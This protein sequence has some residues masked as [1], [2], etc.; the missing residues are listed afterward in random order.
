VQ[1]ENTAPAVFESLKPEKTQVAS[2]DPLQFQ[3]PEIKQ[4]L[5]EKI[6][7]GSAEKSNIGKRADT[8]PSVL[9]QLRVKREETLGGLIQK[10]YGVFNSAYL[11]SLIRINPHIA[12]PDT[13]DVGEVILFPAVPARVKQQPLKQWWVEI[14]NEDSIEAAFKRIRNYPNDAPLSHL[15]P[16]WNQ[17]SGLNF[18]ILLNQYFY[19]EASAMSKIKSL[20]DELKANARVVS[21]WDNQT[22]FYASPYQGISKGS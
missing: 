14:G 3:Q 8:P 16:Y 2:V 7:S 20:P 21:D 1:A 18:S 17:S 12:D 15:V 4:P 19:D 22:V 10:T 6:L 13:I 9:G 5:S 11:N